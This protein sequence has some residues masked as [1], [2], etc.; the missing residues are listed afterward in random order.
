MTADGNLLASAARSFMITNDC[1]SSDD[2]AC[3]YHSASRRRRTTAQ[4]SGKL[5][6]S[7]NT[8]GF[9]Y[10]VNNTFNTRFR[11]SDIMS[12]TRQYFGSW[13]IDGEHPQPSRADAP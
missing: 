7:V 6:P 10:R 3:S 8:Q 4:M 2:L 9:L 13:I 1:T 11:I 5:R 12:I